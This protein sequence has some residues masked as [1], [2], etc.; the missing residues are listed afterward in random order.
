M[1]EPLIAGLGAGTL[2]YACAAVF[3]AAL[4]RG[5]SGF[6]SA[7]IIV[8]SLSL[9]FHPAE[10]VPIA[11]LL[12]VVASLGVLHL[13]W[14]EVARRETAWLLAGACFGTPVGLWLLT[15]VPVN[16]MRA[17]IALIVLAASLSL[18]AQVRLP[19]QSGAGTIMGAGLVSGVVNGAAAVGG[20]PAVL[21]L[22]STDM[23]AAVARA[24]IIVYLMALGVYGTGA[25]YL[26]D[27]ITRDL[28]I[29]TALFCIPLALGVAAGNRHFLAS[30]PDSFRR[31]ALW[32]LIGL[33]CLAL[34]RAAFG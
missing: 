27:L 28:L 5:Y 15:S 8:T 2:A 14:R 18:L 26:N 17:G 24:T 7:A 33:S 23:K 30:S 13:V 10:I 19:R 9:V 21:Y 16:W 20:L 29:R 1:T 25:A 11:V 32:L 34:T 3:F 31:F 12:E 6:G 22:L 4:I